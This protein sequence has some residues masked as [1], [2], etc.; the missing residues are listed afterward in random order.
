MKK[1]SVDLPSSNLKIYSSDDI[2]WNRG[3]ETG[4]VYTKNGEIV[5]GIMRGFY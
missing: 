1:S 3:D 2:D 4:V 5:D